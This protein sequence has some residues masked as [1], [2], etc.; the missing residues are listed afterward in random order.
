MSR[1][2]RTILVSLVAAFALTSVPRETLAQSR[3]SSLKE[4]SRLFAKALVGGDRKA[5]RALLLSHGEI[6]TLS[7]RIPPKARYEKLLKGWL[8]TQLGEFATARKKGRKVRVG[9]AK[10]L[11]VR[12]LPASSKRRRDMVFAVVSPTF[13]VDGKKRSGVPWFFMAHQG[14]WRISIKK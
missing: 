14:R 9:E 6:R 8:D 5:A 4:A 10:V 3:H 11:D 1:V 12:L 7:T 2:L 13:I